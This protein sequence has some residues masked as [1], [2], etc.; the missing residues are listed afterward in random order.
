MPKYKVPP[1][2]VW[3]NNAYWRLSERS[4]FGFGYYKLTSNLKFHPK[5]SFIIKEQMYSHLKKKQA[6]I[7]IGEPVVNVQIVDAIP[8]TE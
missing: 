5:G 4:L 1:N 3:L 2:Y 8:Y 6:L 7:V